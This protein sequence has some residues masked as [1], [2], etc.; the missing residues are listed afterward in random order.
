MGYSYTDAAGKVL[1][2]WSN[3]CR[4][5][6]NSSN[7]FIHGDCRY[8]FEES[9]EDQSDGG[10]VGEVFRKLNANNCVSIGIFR[11]RGDGTID[12]MPRVLAMWSGMVTS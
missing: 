5:Q 8:F 6:T 4:K 2:A 7:D 9:R 10:I 3:A 11:V 12:H 1:D